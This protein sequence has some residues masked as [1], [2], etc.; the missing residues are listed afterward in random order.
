[1]S[2]VPSLIHTLQNLKC[3]HAT[4][5][6]PSLLNHI[7][8]LLSS[9]MSAHVQRNL[10]TGMRTILYSWCVL[11]W[12]WIRSTSNRSSF[13]TR[14][15]FKISWF[16]RKPPAVIEYKVHALSV[17][18]EMV[19]RKYGQDS[20]VGF[21]SF[22]LTYLR[23]LYFQFRLQRDWGQKYCPNPFYCYASLGAKL[24]IKRL[25]VFVNSLLI[26]KS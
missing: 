17:S 23:H 24:N 2:S 11:R 16:I 26:A 5:I 7:R 18:I 25:L 21:P 15:H 6:N 19:F 8:D 22:F 20:Y 1:M 10:T 12:A 13:N 9:S 4:I 14:R 3:T